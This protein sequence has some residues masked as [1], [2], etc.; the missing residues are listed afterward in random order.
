MVGAAA[1]RTG[2]GAQRLVHD[3]PDGAHAAAALGAAAEAAIDLAGPA[4]RGGGDR[5]ADIV[6]GEDVAGTDDHGKIQTRLCWRLDAMPFRPASKGKTLIY[7]NSKV[8]VM[9]DRRG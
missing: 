7:S 6:V 5:A 1:A 8:R 4:R 3:A 2:R 9:H